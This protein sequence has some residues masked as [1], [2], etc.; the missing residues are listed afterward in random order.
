M[1]IKIFILKHICFLIRICPL[2]IHAI[3]ENGSIST[4]RGFLSFQ[5]GCF[6]ELQKVIPNE[7]VSKFISEYQG[8]LRNYPGFELRTVGL[9]AGVSF[10]VDEERNLVFS[11]MQSKGEE[12]GEAQFGPFTYVPGRGFFQNRSP[13][14]GLSMR[15]GTMVSAECVP[16]F[17]EMHGDELRL[18][19]SFFSKRSP[20]ARCGLQIEATKKGGI[21]IEM[22]MERKKEYEKSQLEFFWTVGL[23]KRRRIFSSAC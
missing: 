5:K 9:E 1:K 11:T 13:F 21:H 22:G 19:P 18:I 7:Y 12:E 2:V 15:D 10:F 23:C 8:W 4:K 3:L 6:P 20:I 17:I 16:M 14:E